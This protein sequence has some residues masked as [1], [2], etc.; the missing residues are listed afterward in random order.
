MYRYRVEGSCLQ[1]QGVVL[2]INIWIHGFVVEWFR[3]QVLGIWFQWF[4]LN[5]T[6]GL[7]LAGSMLEI[8]Y[9]LWF[10]CD[11]KRIL[12]SAW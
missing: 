10:P 6:Q 4:S 11:D 2:R 9:I 3:V 5:V 1:S 8:F 7:G 12:F